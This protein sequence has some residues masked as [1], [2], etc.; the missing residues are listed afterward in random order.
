MDTLNEKIQK[1]LQHLDVCIQMLESKRSATL[2]EYIQARELQDIVERE[3][4]KAIQNCI[5]IGARLI[6]IRGFRPPKDYGDV[7]EIIS[8]QGVIDD[9]CCT[10][11]KE[12]AG[13]R[14][15]IVHE[16]RDIDHDEVHRHLQNNLD[17]LR[18][19]ARQVSSWIK[20]EEKN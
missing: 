16:Y 5:D 10:V 3:F 7:F 4:Q 18:T 12:L 19:F 20:K 6:S 8:E 15:I 1:L 9:H 2:N 14:N 17:I 13:L 11:M